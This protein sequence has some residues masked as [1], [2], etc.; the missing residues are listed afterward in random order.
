MSSPT[1]L[2]CFAVSV[3][4]EK[5]PEKC[6]E[7]GEPREK[8]KREWGINPVIGGKERGITCRTMILTSLHLRYLASVLG[9]PEVDLWGGV[10]LSDHLKPMRS[11]I[12]HGRYEGSTYIQY[13]ASGRI[14][15]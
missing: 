13:L 4:A 14:A 2:C 1:S 6:R 10:I 11:R 12:S 5:S 15:P 9:L 7:T 8:N 3:G